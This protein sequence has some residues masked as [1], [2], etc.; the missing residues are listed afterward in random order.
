MNEYDRIKKH[1]SENFASENYW[2]D[3]NEYPFY[4]SQTAYAYLVR[5]LKDHEIASTHELFQKK[6]LDIGAGEGN[7]ILSLLRLGADVRKVTA[8]E[9]TEERFFKLKEKIPY[10][11]LENKNYLDSEK[12]DKYDII[13][14]L[15]VLSS[16]LDVNIENQVIIKAY[17]ELQK[18][19]ILIIYDYEED[20]S[21]N[22]SAYYRSISFKKIIE[23][24][25]LKEEDYSIYSRVY[26][27]A[28]VAKA[29]CKIGLGVLIPFL[30]LIKVFNDR[31]SFLIIKKNIR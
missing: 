6:I 7:F 23:Q 21:K 9:L 29:L 31:Y 3:F 5:I 25:A 2:N 26:I 22:K 27:N 20:I 8:V 15:A 1:Y 14:I 19:G 28:K 16:I 10:A 13:T 4:L 12:K 11:N 18:N 30:Q 24:L 17:S